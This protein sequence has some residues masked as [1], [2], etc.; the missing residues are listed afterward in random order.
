MKASKGFNVE[1]ETIDDRKDC[2]HCKRKFNE[3]A[4][5]KHI[6]LCAAKNRR[7]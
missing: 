1:V 3:G 6:P 2:P 5:V 7:K 4:I